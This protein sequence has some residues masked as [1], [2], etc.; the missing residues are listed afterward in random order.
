MQALFLPARTPLEGGGGIAF[1]APSQVLEDFWTTP[2]YCFLKNGFKC[3]QNWA[4]TLLSEEQTVTHLPQTS[5]AGNTGRERDT[6]K[7]GLPQLHGLEKL[8]V[9]NC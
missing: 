9:L 8:R 1:G 7:Q 6:H 2:E 5:R 3:H 4:H